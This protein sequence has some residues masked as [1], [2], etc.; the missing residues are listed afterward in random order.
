[1]LRH[2]NIVAH[3]S[4]RLYDHRAFISHLL[5][6]R[7]F[8]A[9]NVSPCRRDSHG[10]LVETGPAAVSLLNGYCIDALDHIPAGAMQAEA[11]NDYERRRGRG[12]RGT[13]C[14]ASRGQS[15]AEVEACKALMDEL[16]AEILRERGA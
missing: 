13:Q 2:A 6:E 14:F 10:Y 9:L 4:E 1:M 12:E 7:H 8:D 11:Q 16:I 15:L 3:E 5:D